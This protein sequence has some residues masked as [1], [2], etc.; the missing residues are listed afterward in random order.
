MNWEVEMEDGELIELEA[1]SYWEA[2]DLAEDIRSE[3]GALREAV[4]AKVI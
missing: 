2:M 1:E 3:S 4:T